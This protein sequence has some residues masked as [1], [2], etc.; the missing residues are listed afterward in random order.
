MGNKMN[1]CRAPGCSKW[2][3]RDNEVGYCLDHMGKRDPLSSL[4][5][6]KTSEQLEEDNKIISFFSYLLQ[7]RTPDE[8]LY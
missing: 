3:V 8:L 6:D 7:N 5:A 2:V 4:Y 1:K